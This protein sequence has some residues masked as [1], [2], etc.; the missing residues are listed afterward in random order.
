MSLLR[1]PDEDAQD[2]AGPAT[3]SQ[4]ACVLHSS[5]QAAQG[6]F[7]SLLL[8]GLGDPGGSLSH[9]HHYL[10]LIQLFEFSLLPLQ[11]FL[12][13]A[14]PLLVSLLLFPGL[15]LLEFFFFLLFS[16]RFLVDT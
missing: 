7:A 10:L 1:G 2:W 6:W 16:K 11:S 15:L 8:L 9:Q 5:P 4:K 12:P 3:L 14:L 13:L